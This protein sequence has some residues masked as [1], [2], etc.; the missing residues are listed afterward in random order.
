MLGAQMLF[1]NFSSAE[2][3]DSRHIGNLLRANRN[4]TCEI[5]FTKIEFYVSSQQV[6][7]EKMMLENELKDAGNDKITE[8]LFGLISISYFEFLLEDIS[9]V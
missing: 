9:I 5:C 6:E 8:K 2:K 1:T 3:D 4:P 7:R